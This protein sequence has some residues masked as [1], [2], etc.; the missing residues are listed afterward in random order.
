MKKPS[1]IEN[2]VVK[3]DTYYASNSASEQ[4]KTFNE[5][6][7]EFGTVTV[8]SPYFSR[9]FS[10]LTPNLSGRPGLTRNDY[11]QFRP[12]ERIPTKHKDIVKF[13]ERVYKKNGLV[14]NIIDLMGDFACQGIRISCS[15]KRDERFYRNWFNRVGGIDRS[16]RFANNL[17]RTG[18][19][20]IR[21][22]TATIDLKTRSKLFKASGKSDLKIERSS[23]EG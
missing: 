22:Q 1:P 8:G 2:A 21:R 9:D 7:G 4:M 19:I 23:K 11:D 3:L 6:A 20:I 12:S 18:N 5:A 14:H 16:E 15:N 13:A 17:Y 10:N